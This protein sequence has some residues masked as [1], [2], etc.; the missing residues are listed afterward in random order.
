MALRLIGGSLLPQNLRSDR[1]LILW[2]YEH[3]E[4]TKSMTTVLPDVV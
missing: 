4:V 1:Y 2:K 3:E